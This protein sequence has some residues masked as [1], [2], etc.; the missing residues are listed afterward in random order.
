MNCERAE[1][2]LP[3]HAGGDLEDARERAALSAHLAGCDA[4]RRRAGEWAEWAEGLSLLRADE[5]PEFDAAF[6]DPIRREV[7]R[8]IGAARPPAHPL[9]TLFAA[10]LRPKPLAYA[11]SLA[12]V[13]AALPFALRLSRAPRPAKTV[14]DGVTAT[15]NRRLSSE[16]ATPTPGRAV[17]HENAGVKKTTR[18]LPQ[19][20]GSAASR[21]TG[22]TSPSSRVTMARGADGAT[23][24]PAVAR[25][26]PQTQSPPPA[27]VLTPGEL[28]GA[29]VE[30]AV[31]RDEREMLKIDLRT[32][33]PDVRIIWFSPQPGAN[34]S[35]LRPNDK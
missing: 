12:L 6:F 34:A 13:C 35:P 17:V 10:L 15:L 31:V 5:P 23:A 25:V 21:A 20:E 2:L 14:G 16:R 30:L 27:V 4:C 19:R 28:P 8:E 33:D 26:E 11:A 9:A 3:L 32:G 24:Q 22:E 29:G 18:A 1:R 7:M